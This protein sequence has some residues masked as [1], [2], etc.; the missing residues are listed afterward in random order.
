MP[1]FLGIPRSHNTFYRKCGTYTQPT[2]PPSLPLLH[3]IHSPH[4]L[5]HINHLHH[6]SLH[7]IHPLF[8]TTHPYSHPQPLFITLHVTQPLLPPSLLLLHTI[9]S[10]HILLHIN[11]LHHLS[12]R[13]IH[14]LSSTTHPYSHP[15]PLF[16]TLHVTQPLLPTIP[17]SLLLLRTINSPNI[18]LHINAKALWG[19]REREM[20][21]SHY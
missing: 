11:H 16:I 8:S 9:H 14:P 7:I 10:P 3:T 15:H 4:I 6:L 2:L 21:F 19:E 5:L 20:W 12:L 18:L 13:I 1:H 17:P